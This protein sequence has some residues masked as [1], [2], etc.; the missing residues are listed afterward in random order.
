MIFKT[1]AAERARYNK[2]SFKK[3]LFKSAL[4]IC[5]IILLV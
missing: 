2:P 4:V 3:S 5:I 1:T